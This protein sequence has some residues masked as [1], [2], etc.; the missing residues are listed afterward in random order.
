MDIVR[1][2]QVGL[3]ILGSHIGPDHLE[4]FIEWRVFLFDTK[5]SIDAYLVAHVLV[6]AVHEVVHGV[7]DEEVLCLFHLSMLLVLLHLPIQHVLLCLL[8]CLNLLLVEIGVLLPAHS[9]V[10]FSVPDIGGVGEPH[11]VSVVS[12]E[13]CVHAEDL[14][15][16][17]LFHVVAHLEALLVRISIEVSFLEQS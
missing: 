9:A 15:V 8:V 12:Q 1:L 13:L 3:E 2:A 7:H 14:L 4:D 6:V 10:A 5:I 16:A 11:I 17:H